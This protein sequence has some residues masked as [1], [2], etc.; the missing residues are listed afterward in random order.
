VSLTVSY[1]PRKEYR[2]LIREISGKEENFL[3]DIKYG[4]ILGSDKFVE[5]VQKKFIDPISHKR[6]QSE[7]PVIIKN[8]NAK[9]ISYFSRKGDFLCLTGAY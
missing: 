3:E 7:I 2:K 4:M 9:N 1:Y 6:P 5:W 8:D